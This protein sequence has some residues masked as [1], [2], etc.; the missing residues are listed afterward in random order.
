[1]GEREKTEE[2]EYTNSL[3]DKGIR[4]TGVGIS[5]LKSQ[6]GET[7]F[8]KFWAMEWAEF[9]EFNAYFLSR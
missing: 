6:V 9:V 3:T 7:L 2:I 5:A 8:G 4:L 1:M